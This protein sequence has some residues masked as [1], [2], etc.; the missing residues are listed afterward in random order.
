MKS[1]YLDQSIPYTGGEL[2]SHWILNKAKLK[3]DAI[4]AFAGP[5][6]VKI[7][8]MVDLEDVIANEPIFSESMLHFIVEF[9]NTDLEKTILLQRLLVSNMENILRSFKKDLQV[10]RSGDDLYV[11][12]KKLTVSIAT[13]S[14]VSTLIH[15]GINISSKNTPVPTLGLGDLA[16]EPKKFAITVMEKFVEEVEGVKWARAKVRGVM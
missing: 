4:V 10:L 13:A 8:K 5:C 1:L 15:T 9:F 11:D 6:E 3:G 12:E 2:C 7:D 16:I 14:P